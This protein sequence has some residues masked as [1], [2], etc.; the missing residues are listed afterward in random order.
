MNKKAG[1]RDSVNA[2]FSSYDGVALSPES[3]KPLVKCIVYST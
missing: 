1:R 2:F 3:E